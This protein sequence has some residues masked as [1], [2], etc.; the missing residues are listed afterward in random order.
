MKSLIPAPLVATYHH[1]MVAE[2]QARRSLACFYGASWVAV[3]HSRVLFFVKQGVALQWDRAVVLR[4]GRFHSLK[5]PGIFFLV[6][7]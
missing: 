5:G 3:A 1:A 4:L 2:D 7:F 6:P